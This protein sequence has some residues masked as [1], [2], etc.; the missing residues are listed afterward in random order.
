MTSMWARTTMRSQRRALIATALLLGL[1]GAIVLGAAAGARRTA[2]ASSRYRAETL[3]PEGFVNVESLLNSGA[4]PDE[5]AVGLDSISELPGVREI[6][7]FA[8]MGVAATDD[9]GAPVGFGSFVPT[10]HRMGTT[11]G[12]T[13]V[14]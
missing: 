12:R 9:R 5:V 14:H 7:P 3:M 11:I 1:V 6:A 2:S 4:D 10:D 8:F 13:L